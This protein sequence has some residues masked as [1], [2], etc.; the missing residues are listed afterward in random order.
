MTTQDD[1][2]RIALLLPQAAESDNEFGCRV[3]GRQFVPLW[4]ERVDPKEAK[5]ANAEVIVVQVVD[6]GEKEALLACDPAKF[7]TTDHDDGYTAG[8]VRLPRST[9]RSWR[10]W[11]A[12]PGGYGRPPGWS[13]SWIGR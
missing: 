13:R 11:S 4:R 2:R 1:L 12:T 7:F 9:S 6:L 3:A 5:V 8:L 10:S